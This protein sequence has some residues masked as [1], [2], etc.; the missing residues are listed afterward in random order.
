MPIRRRPKKRNAEPRRKSKRNRAL[1]DP[2]VNPGSPPYR[3]QTRSKANPTRKYH[4]MV[5]LAQGAPGRRT[6]SPHQKTATV[7]LATAD[8]WTLAVCPASRKVVAAG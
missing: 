7:M 2:L 5:I 1:I 4:R 6:A 8:A 3:H